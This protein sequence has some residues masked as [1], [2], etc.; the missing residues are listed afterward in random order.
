MVAQESLTAQRSR[1]GTCAQSSAGQWRSLL[2]EGQL[3]PTTVDDA[4]ISATPDQQIVLVT[5]GTCHIESRSG[6]HW[7][8][9]QYRAGDLGMVAPGEETRLRWRSERVH[10]TLHLY[11]PAELL[12]SVHADLGRGA[13]A[14]ADLPSNLCRQD[15]LIVAVM[16]AV[17][18]AAEVGA[19]ELYAESAAYFLASHLFTLGAGRLEPPRRPEPAALA[20][21]DE[22]MRAHLAEPLTLGE[23][24]LRAGLSTFQY[25]RAAKSHWQET[26][27]RRLTRLR[28]ELARTLLRRRRSVT[29]V[30]LSCGYGNPSHFATAFRRATGMTPSRYQQL[31]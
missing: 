13:P 21:S 19:P 16:R 7:R 28:M 12:L 29:D 17:A 1:P 3:N 14:L 31:Y 30:A 6:R 2:V 18:Q 8:R 4:L 26:P 23:L 15:P 11:L 22:Y 5:A 25:L 9:A 20:L 27:M 10:T 24:A